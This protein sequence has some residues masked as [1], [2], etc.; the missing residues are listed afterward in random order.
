MKYPKVTLIDSYGDPLRTMYAMAQNMRGNMIHDTSGVTNEEAIETLNEFDPA[1]TRLTGV[2]EF[3]WFTFQV[4]GV[5][6]AF[7]HQLVR[8]RESAFS[9]E[10]L[11]FTEKEGEDFQFDI[12]PTIAGDDYLKILYVEKMKD[13]AETCRML[14]KMGAAQEDIRGLYPI[15]ILTKIGFQVN[16]RRL[17]TIAEVRM[18]HQSQKHWRNIMW[19]IREQIATKVNAGEFLAKWLMPACDRSGR[20]EFK[21]L[22]DRECPKE[23]ILKDN[24]CHN[25]EMFSNNV[26]RGWEEPCRAMEVFMR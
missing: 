10:S 20:C 6:R 17:I 9:Q 4:E 8:H 21:S 7:T 18:C 23:K 16:F 19:Q 12:G 1:K 24:I 13:T 3:A 25:C 15:N 5:P 11:R 26:C 22:W 2:L 14:S